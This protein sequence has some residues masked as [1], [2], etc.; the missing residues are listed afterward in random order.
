MLKAVSVS[1]MQALAATSENS[2]E[3][4]EAR[5]ILPGMATQLRKVCSQ[6]QTYAILHIDI[7]VAKS[8]L[9]VLQHLVNLRCVV[10]QWSVICMPLGQAMCSLRS[11]NLTS[12]LIPP[13]LTLLMEPSLRADSFGP[14]V[15]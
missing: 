5:R 2:Q 15:T 12:R 10:L 6:S 11:L 1:Y 3:R 8:C 4:F 7:A 13:V 9:Y 14:C